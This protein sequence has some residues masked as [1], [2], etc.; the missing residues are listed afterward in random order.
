MNY[1]EQLNHFYDLLQCNYIS[2]NAQLLYHTLLMIN[3]KCSWIEWFQRTNISLCGLLG[4]S[5]NT[6]KKARNELKQ[7][8]L[9]DF[10]QATKKGQIT[11][12]KIIKVSKCKVE[13]DTNTDTNADTNPDT[14]TDTNTDDIDKQKPKQ[15]LN[16]ENK[17]ESRKETY[18]NIVD[19]LNEKAGTN[20][21]STTKGTQE[22]INARLNEGFNLDD[23]KVVINKK[24]D[25]WLKDAK[26]CKYLRPET[27]F[28]NKF[29][30]YLNEV[31][32]GSNN[33]DI[34]DWVSDWANGKE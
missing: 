20:Y 12:Y 29:E 22:K 11:K 3:N 15:K 33:N 8:N 2:N 21:K 23:F 26:M 14:N 34:P 9:I 13:N 17:K 5:E 31:T 19:Y 1:I 18:E 4:I 27:L 30:S 25:T 10:Q 24:C 28:G 7:Y 16:K 6:L 32:K